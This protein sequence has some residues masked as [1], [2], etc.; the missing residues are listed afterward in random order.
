MSVI[1]P[2]ILSG[3]SGTRLWPASRAS[4]PKQ[5]L[6]LVGEHTMLQE[7][8]LRLDGKS[9]VSKDIIV[10][11]N[12]AHRFEVAGQLQ[13]IAKAARIVLEPVG[14]NTAP[15]AALA[16]LLALRGQPDGEPPLL[17]IM[18]ADHVIRDRAALLG[19]VEAAEPAAAAGQLVMFGI[20]PSYP[21]TGYGY[22][23]AE[24]TDGEAAPIRSFVEKPDQK[25]AVQLL[26]T[27]R[28]FWNGGIFLVRADTYIAELEKFEPAMLA[29]CRAS[30]EAM[31]E[32]ADFLRPD[33][34]AFAACPPNSI[35]YAVMERT[36]LGAM[37]PMTAGWSDVGSWSALYDV[38]A[39]DS[40]GNALSGDVIAHHCKSTFIRA[41]SRLVTAVGLENLIVVED[42]DAVLVV[43]RDHAQGV[44]AVV[45]QLEAAGRL[46]TQQRARDDAAARGG[47]AAPGDAQATSERKA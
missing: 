7:T 42:G 37:V 6:S 25:T 43:H 18:P 12:E 13:A 8:A 4:F 14:R 39:K 15:A 47:A 23:E 27:N 46:E 9:N 45:E 26:E 19:A 17:L 21:H 10:V 40:D 1:Q 32:D 3:G 2:V 20:V 11:C 30:I 44:K 5:L 38:S 28:Y 16:A 34:A 35:D 29:A 33:A 24:A 31:H 41:G 36:E 22:I